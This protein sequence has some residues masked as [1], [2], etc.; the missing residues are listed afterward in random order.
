MN[1]IKKSAALSFQ[2]DIQAY[3]KSVVQISTHDSK[4]T[5]FSISEDGRNFITNA[6]VIEDALSLTVYFPERRYI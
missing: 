2:S 1:S 3:K 6:H 5:G 4:G